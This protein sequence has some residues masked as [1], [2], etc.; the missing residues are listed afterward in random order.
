MGKRSR[1]FNADRTYGRKE[2]K[3]KIADKIISEFKIIREFERVISA[4]ENRGRRAVE[5]QD[6][7]R[8]KRAFA[9]K[10]RRERKR[11]KGKERERKTI[12]WLRYFWL[13]Y[14]DFRPPYPLK[15]YAEHFVFGLFLKLK[16][17]CFV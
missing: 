4:E 7:P 8:L 3:R 5:R 11:K 16:N 13:R 10:R 17:L 12:S 6:C 1:K 2:R 15:D 9:R 14:L